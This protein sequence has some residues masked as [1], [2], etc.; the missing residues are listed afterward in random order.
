MINPDMQRPTPGYR[1]KQYQA[2]RK[3]QEKMDRDHRIIL[4]VIVGVPVGLV[5]L[6]II[7]V[8][9]E[10]VPL[11]WLSSECSGRTTRQ[12]GRLALEARCELPRV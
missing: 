2:E 4:S 1:Y 10:T 11:L 3:E 6:F 5:V 8:K 7:I 12:D 9:T